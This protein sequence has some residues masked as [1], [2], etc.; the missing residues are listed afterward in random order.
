MSFSFMCI[1][2]NHH[3][4]F[5]NVINH[6]IMNKNENVIIQKK[7]IMTIK[8]DDDIYFFVHFIMLNDS[9]F[10]NY[11]ND[12]QIQISNVMNF[13]SSN[14]FRAIFNVE[15]ESIANELKK[16]DFMFIYEKF[17]RKLFLKWHVKTK[18][19]TFNDVKFDKKHAFDVKT[20]KKMQ[21]YWNF[22]KQNDFWK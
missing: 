17:K 16:F 11:A 14:V 5:F 6:D 1:E 18:W 13:D 19:S 7:N 8:N 3:I 22:D 2:Q 10:Q 15:R 4:M 9:Q 12:F 21:I 20:K